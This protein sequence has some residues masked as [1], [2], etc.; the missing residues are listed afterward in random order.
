MALDSNDLFPIYR[1]SDGTNRKASI[2]ALL[3]M[4]AGPNN[5]TISF[6]GSQGITYP[7]T[8]SFTL[9]QAGDVTIDI[10]GPDLSGLLEKPSTD[11]TYV[12]SVASGAV[13]YTSYESLE[14]DGGVYA[15]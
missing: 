11:G 10:A 9:N 8:N 4:G 14:V 2:G 12:I 1:G 13:T 15:V 7:S 5:G 3:A 6:T